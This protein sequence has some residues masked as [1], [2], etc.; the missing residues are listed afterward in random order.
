[1]DLNRIHPETIRREQLIFDSPNRWDILHNFD[2][3]QK[4]T[5]EF[6]RQALQEELENDPECTFH[7]QLS[8]MSEWLMRKHAK[9]SF[10]ERMDIWARRREQNMKEL[11]EHQKEEQELEYSFTPEIVKR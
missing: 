1:M 5:R 6:L 4:Q 7:P 3:T 9:L 8:E 2:K 11:K 10:L